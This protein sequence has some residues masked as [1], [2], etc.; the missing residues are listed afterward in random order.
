MAEDIQTQIP[1]RSDMTKWSRAERMIFE[2]VEAVEALPADRRLT[3]AVV[4]L[5]AARESVADYIDKGPRI[6]RVVITET[7]Q[8]EHGTAMD[9]HCCGCH[10]GFLF[11]TQSCTCLDEKSYG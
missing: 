2:A 6:P 1:R 11:D 4:L 3:D 8:C 10:S 7:P 5:Q 9:V